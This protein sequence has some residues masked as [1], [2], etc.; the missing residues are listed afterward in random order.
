MKDRADKGAPSGW[1]RPRWPPAPLRQGLVIDMVSLPRYICTQEA[2][3]GCLSS[4]MQ[5][6]RVLVARGI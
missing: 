1:T 3:Y 5:C 2:G 6:R 4:C